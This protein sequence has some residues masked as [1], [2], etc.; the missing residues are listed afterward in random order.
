[1]L[2]E[3]NK[4]ESRDVGRRLISRIIQPL[5]SFFFLYFSP[6]KQTRCLVLW[7]VQSTSCCHQGALLTF[8][9]SLALKPGTSTW[10]SRSRFASVTA[11]PLSQAATVHLANKIFG[12]DR[13]CYIFNKN[14]VFTLWIAL[15]E[16]HSHKS[17]NQAKQA[18]NQ[19]ALYIWDFFSQLY[20]IIYFHYTSGIW[21]LQWWPHQ[22]DRSWA[23]L[24]SRSSAPVHS[25]AR[26]VVRC[27]PN[28]RCW[29]LFCWRQRSCQGS[30]TR[31]RATLFFRWCHLCTCISVR[32]QWV[33]N[34]SRA[35]KSCSQCWTFP[36]LPHSVRGKMQDCLCWFA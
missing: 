31:P 19:A 16:Q 11:S 34:T 20:F 33:S 32:R 9:A 30:K 26:C 22:T 21:T 3:N 2:K 6:S 35:Q 15:F 4:L 27:I 29:E 23:R 10:G 12:L 1:M 24:R 17:R 8:I 28:F 18:L 25:S 5:T 14:L 36:Q 7:A 13:F